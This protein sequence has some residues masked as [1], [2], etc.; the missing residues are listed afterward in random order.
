VAA[1]S[2]CPAHVSIG[3]K[4]LL[5]TC[6]VKNLLVADYSHFIYNG[7]L[8]TLIYADRGNK[9][10]PHQLALLRTSPDWKW[11]GSRPSVLRRTL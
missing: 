9:L 5:I 7:N 6:Q 10:K 11:Q 1:A 3:C 4:P 2:A 8:Y